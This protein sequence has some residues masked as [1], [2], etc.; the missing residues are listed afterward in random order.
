MNFVAETPEAKYIY[1][2]HFP[3]ESG[4]SL[5]QK[6]A[7]FF[8]DDDGIKRRIRLHDYNEIYKY[9]GLYEQL[10]YDRLQCSSPEVVTDRLARA[11]QN[12]ACP[13]EAL[14]LLD[15]G[16]GN[17]I[18]GEA[19]KARNASRIVGLDIIAEARDAA[20]R[21]RPGVYDEYLVTDMTA[22]PAAD[23]RALLDWRLDAV[24]CVAA[25]G[26]DD[27]PA[28]AFVRALE[29]IASDGWMAFTIKADFLGAAD[30][31]GFATLIKTLL[32]DNIVEL[33]HM[34]RYRHRLSIDG[35]WLCYFVVIARK[36][37]KLPPL[38]L[39][40][41]GAGAWRRAGIRP[42]RHGSAGA[43]SAGAE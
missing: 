7:Y 27:I 40:R 4:K 5:S 17:G 37:G 22:L 43:R 34:E 21:D 25:L 14:R 38:L 39:D 42:Q 19:L 24:C 30:T 12:A 10:F 13:I 23:H 3:K 1:H 8:I 28:T 6:E 32:H 9:V 33:H 20:L 35:E 29:L 26:F 11:L 31:S 41:Y 15:L 16:A 36:R 18:V 2:I